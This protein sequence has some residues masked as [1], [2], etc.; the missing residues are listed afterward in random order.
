MQVRC[1]SE[2][3]IVVSLGLGVINP[4]LGVCGYVFHLPIIFFIVGERGFGLF[5]GVVMGFGVVF[6]LF[7]GVVCYCLATE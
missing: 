7:L 4:D 6:C 5:L 3:A 1:C 2:P